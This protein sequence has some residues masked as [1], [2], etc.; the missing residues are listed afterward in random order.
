MFININ[1]VTV[2]RCKTF[3][4][5]AFDNS[6]SYYSSSKGALSRHQIP[7][8]PTTG[9]RHHRMVHWVMKGRESRRG[10]F[11]TGSTRA[12]PGRYRVET[13]TGRHFEASACCYNR[14]VKLRLKPLI[15]LS[16]SHTSRTQARVMPIRLGYGP[17]GPFQC[18]NGPILNTSDKTRYVFL[19]VFS[20]VFHW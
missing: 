13:R 6:A 16:D 9:L 8:R 7:R 17:A 15:Q 12:N 10:E 4:R 18:P 19:K 5:I 3:W 14:R 1:L 2:R 11:E 20:L